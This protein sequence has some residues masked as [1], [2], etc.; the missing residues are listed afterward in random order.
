MGIVQWHD[1]DYLSLIVFAIVSVIGIWVFSLDLS[2]SWFAKVP[3]PGRFGLRDLMSFSKGE[4]ATLAILILA[5][6]HTGG[7]TYEEARLMAS[8]CS[9]AQS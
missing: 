4:H 5:V 1:L 6:R 9:G 8:E 7:F 3:L 2:H